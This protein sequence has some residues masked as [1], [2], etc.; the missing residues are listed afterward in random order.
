[1]KLTRICS[2]APVAALLPACVGQH[3]LFIY[4]VAE[5]AVGTLPV[6]YLRIPARDLVDGGEFSGFKSAPRWHLLQEDDAYDKLSD[7]DFPGMVLAR[8]G[9]GNAKEA[10]KSSALWKRDIKQVV[11]IEFSRVYLHLYLARD[12]PSADDDGTL[13]PYIVAELGGTTK[14]IPM[15][16]NTCNPVYWLSVPFDVALPKDLSYAPMMSLK[17]FDYDRF[18]SD[19]YIGTSRIDLSTKAFRVSAKDARRLPPQKR[20][21][22]L[23][24]KR[25]YCDWNEVQNH[26]SLSPHPLRLHSNVPQHD[27]AIRWRLPWCHSCQRA[28]CCQ[29]RLCH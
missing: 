19:D 10:R 18:S 20:A 2:H 25:K 4:L 21:E 28:D 17:V 7:V 14:K 1:M 5:L 23:F 22:K 16:L 3:D 15:Q 27:G 8:I 9:F 24:P 29:G 11:D 12:L 6:T 13:D 26:W